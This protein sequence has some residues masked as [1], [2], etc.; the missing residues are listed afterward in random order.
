M[1]KALKLN[2]TV[3]IYDKMVDKSLINISSLFRLLFTLEEIL[4]QQT[5]TFCEEQLTENLVSHKVAQ[6]HKSFHQ[7]RRH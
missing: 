6:T 7:F 2:V 5:E 4:L 1:V 3:F